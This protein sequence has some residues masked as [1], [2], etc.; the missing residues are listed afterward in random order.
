MGL[1][2]GRGS[3]RDEI[4]KSRGGP[5]GQ[6]AIAMM[7]GIAAPKPACPQLSE[8]I[9]AVAGCKTVKVV[10]KPGVPGVTVS[11]VRSHLDSITS[12]QIVQ[13]GFPVTSQQ[14]FLIDGRS[15][16]T[17]LPEGSSLLLLY[18]ERQGPLAEW[19]AGQKWLDRPLTRF[20]RIGVPHA[21]QGSPTRSKTM[22]E[23]WKSPAM[24]AASR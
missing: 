24:P 8:Q 6:T 16:R 3:P 11:V 9:L 13:K 18:T 5:G 14:V 12:A 7:G 15:P 2:G 4:A 19:H 1:T 10:L 20:T 21:R 22:W 23:N 17:S